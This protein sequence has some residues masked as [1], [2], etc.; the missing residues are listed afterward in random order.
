MT[1]GSLLLALLLA[2]L[3]LLPLPFNLLLRR[4]TSLQ[5]RRVGRLLLLRRYANATPD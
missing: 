1:L 4:Q 5:L 3:H 2:L